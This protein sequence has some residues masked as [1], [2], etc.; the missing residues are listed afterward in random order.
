[1]YLSLEL[2]KPYSKFAGK[3]YNFNNARIDVGAKL[4]F[5]LV[6]RASLPAGND[7]VPEART[8]ALL[9]KGQSIFNSAV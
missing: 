8:F 1:L 3:S 9:G 4:E 2:R 5:L 6:G 7:Q